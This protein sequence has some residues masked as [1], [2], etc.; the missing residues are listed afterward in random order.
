VGKA[1][2]SGNKSLPNVCLNPILHHTITMVTYL[3]ATLDFLSHQNLRTSELSLI[4][5]HVQNVIGH[6]SFKMRYFKQA[7]NRGIDLDKFHRLND[8]IVLGKDPKGII[9]ANNARSSMKDL[10]NLR[11]GFIAR[12]SK[13]GK[14][15]RSRHVIT[16]LLKDVRSS[17]SPSK[18]ITDHAWVKEG[19]GNFLNMAS[20]TWVSFEARV[21]TYSKRNGGGSG[22]GKDF[23]FFNPRKIEEC[24]CP[25]PSLS[26]EASLTL[27]SLSLSYDSSD[28]EDINN[29]HNNNT[30]INIIDLCDDDSCTTV[31]DLDK[32]NNGIN[33]D[34]NVIVISDSD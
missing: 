15:K 11:Q 4:R 9:L 3:E 13:R 2:T 7:I 27:A 10:R 28:S 20:N 33:D 5:L 29:G 12:I 14:Q 17:T 25:P 22:G 18:I 34:D 1:A 21:Q 30:S 19:T 8:L 23:R 26:M 6:E 24:I 16:I 32:N 31:D